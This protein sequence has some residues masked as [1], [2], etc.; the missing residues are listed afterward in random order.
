MHCRSVLPL[1]AGRSEFLQKGGTGDFFGFHVLIWIVLGILV[2]CPTKTLAGDIDDWIA[3]IKSPALEPQ[4]GSLAIRPAKVELRQVA[5][6]QLA[7]AFPSATCYPVV[8]VYQLGAEPGLRQDIIENKDGREQ[9]VGS[10]KL[11][12]HK[13]EPSSATVILDFKKRIRLAI[14]D[15]DYVVTDM[16][17]RP[18]EKDKWFTGEVTLKIRVGGEGKK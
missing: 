18:I 15:K 16:E 6:G 5:P 3:E 8:K 12:W 1:S 11:V 14:T 7:N 13:T 4:G 17:G 2:W 10:V 9:V